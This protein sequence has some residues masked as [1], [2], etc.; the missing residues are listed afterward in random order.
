MKLIRSGPV[1]GVVVAASMGAAVLAADAPKRPTTRPTTRPAAQT[2]PADD[3]E[4]ALFDGKTLKNWQ[5]TEFGGEADVAV[6]NGAIVVG[7]GATLSGVNWK[8]PDLPKMDYEIGLDAMRLEGSDF[9]L[10]LTFPVGKSHASLIL[11]GWGGSLVGISSINGFD[12]A[13]NDTAMAKEFKSNKWYHVR[14]RVTRNKLEAWIDDDKVIDADTT[15]KEISVRADI[16]AAIPLGL[17]TYQ[18]KAAYKN[19]YL[20][21]L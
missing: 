7:S 15:D 17:S 9:F 12:A 1:V 13:N 21:R 3:K 19:V 2:K 4:M 18:T 10:G 5:K 16:D 8:G 6:E 14:L 20:R 11:G